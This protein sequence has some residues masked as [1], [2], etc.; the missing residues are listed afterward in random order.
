MEKE[1]VFDESRRFFLRDE[2]ILKVS[3]GSMRPLI[4][5]RDEV[6]VKRWDGKV[7]RNVGDI[8][9]YKVKD[10]FF[11]HR[12]VK[13]Q[14][15]G[16]REWGIGRKNF[17]L[18]ERAKFVVKD[19]AGICGAYAVSE[20]DIIGKVTG[21]ENRWLGSLVVRWLG[22]GKC[23]LVYNK[24]ISAIFKLF[25]PIKHK[26]L[27][28]FFSFFIF[29]FSFFIIVVYAAN[30]YVSPS[31]NDNNPGME[32][33]PWRTISKAA[34]TVVAGDIVNVKKGTYF[35]TVSPLNSGKVDALIIYQAEP[36]TVLTGL[37][38]KGEKVY[39]YGFYLDDKSYIKIAGFTVENYLDTGI[40]ATGK[41]EGGSHDIFIASN[42][43]RNNEGQGIW[44][45]RTAHSEVIGN[46]CENNAVGIYIDQS[47]DIT[48]KYNIV[49][50]QKEQGIGFC[51]ANNSQAVNNTCYGNSIGIEFRSYNKNCSAKNNLITKNVYGILFHKPLTDTSLVVNSNNFFD[52][53]KDGN[54]FISGQAKKD[55]KE[56]QKDDVEVDPEF[57]DEKNRNFRL[58]PKSPVKGKGAFPE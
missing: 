19:D 43:C 58:S 3:G 50:N 53:S 29:H 1:K 17:F 28:F 56:F 14:G 20:K 31:G 12:I 42:T 7:T 30:Y 11:I 26:I 51:A 39:K 25:R 49:L 37:N 8:V 27:P 40:Y 6:R 55:W 57:V 36:E 34:E 16:N 48:A 41:G 45:E 4:R 13:R 5:N 10:K 38:A 9:L 21:I 33:Q 54:Y 2:F 15:S 23:G 46:W 44:I 52:N 24:A 22:K 18:E 47:G 32:T 35:E